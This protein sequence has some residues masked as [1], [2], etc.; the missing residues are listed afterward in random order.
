MRQMPEL[1]PPLPASDGSQ[2]PAGVLA[3][4]SHVAA[5]M[6]ML[7]LQPNSASARRQSSSTQDHHAALIPQARQLHTTRV[8]EAPP[9]SSAPQTVAGP[10]ARCFSQSTR[11]T[12]PTLSRTST[13]T[14]VLTRT[15]QVLMLGTAT[16]ARDAKIIVAIGVADVRCQISTT[17]W[18]SFS[19]LARQD[20]S[21]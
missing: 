14:S 20:S 8:H 15:L 19:A 13:T 17:G 7:R 10:H 16:S 5:G 6:R 11:S 9:P 2:F 18:T 12:S 1:E 4:T 21:G 3:P